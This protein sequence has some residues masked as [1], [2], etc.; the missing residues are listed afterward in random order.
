VGCGMS[1]S[2][3]LARSPKGRIVS[4]VSVC[5]HCGEPLDVRSIRVRPGPGATE[6]DFDCTRVV[7]G[8]RRRSRAAV[9]R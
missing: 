7:V 9:S 8:S 4:A 2:G 1:P 3:R 6:G 5:S